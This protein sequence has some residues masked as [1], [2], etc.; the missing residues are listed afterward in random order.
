MPMDLAAKRDELLLM[1][2][3]GE[4]YLRRGA[5]LDVLKLG[6]M[7]WRFSR[8]VGQYQRLKHAELFLPMMAAPAAGTRAEGERLSS[9]CLGRGSELRGF[10]RRWD[11][12]AILADA[13][14]YR[15]EALELSERTRR[16]IVE[17]SALMESLQPL[18]RAA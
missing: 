2:S 10:F 18:V 9:E 1:L 4:T 11:A 13:D 7:R 14:G 5:E 17:E 12:A 3:E 15:H 8:A 16:C 6:R